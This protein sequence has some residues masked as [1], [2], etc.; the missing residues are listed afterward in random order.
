V[1]SGR[2]ESRVEPAVLLKLLGNDVR[3]RLVAALAASDRKVNELVEATGQ[4]PNL[5]SYHLGQLRAARMVG[6]RRSSADARDVYYS[7]DLER[8]RA[9]FERCAVTIHPGLWPASGKDATTAGSADAA[10]RPTRVLFLCTHNSARSQMAEAIL[11]RQGA[12]A[13][14]VRSAGSDPSEVHPLALRTLA[15]LGIDGAGLHAKSLS[16]F[17]GER[18]HCVITLCDIVR[19][20]CPSWPGEPEQLHWSLADPSLVDASDEAALLAF[21]TTAGEISRRARYFLKKAASGGD[22][23]AAQRRRLASRPD[24]GRPLRGGLMPSSLADS[25]SIQMDNIY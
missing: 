9:A 20:K 14:D 5:V 13:V 11:R 19:E 8:L 18:F 23:H 22:V 15:E 16:S 1:S 2:P 24:L 3:W 7:L 6:E 21:R 12:G 4:P 10:P 25:S 17:A